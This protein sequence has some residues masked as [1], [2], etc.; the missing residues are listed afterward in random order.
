MVATFLQPLK[1]FLQLF[2]TL[3]ATF[4]KP[5]GRRIQQRRGFS[6]NQCCNFLGRKS[7]TNRKQPKTQSETFSPHEGECPSNQLGNFPSWERC[8]AKEKAVHPFGQTAPQ[9][10]RASKT[11]RP[12]VEYARGT[13]RPNLPPNRSNLSHCGYSRYAILLSGDIRKGY[14]QS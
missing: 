10:R 14:P 7:K 4:L 11:R 9:P 2:E 6:R 8:P 13:F 12:I 3:G 1:L 5:C